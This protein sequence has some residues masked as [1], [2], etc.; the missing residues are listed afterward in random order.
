VS[1][2][3]ASNCCTSITARVTSRP[4]GDSCSVSWNSAA[5]IPKKYDG[6]N[7]KTGKKL[8]HTPLQD[9]SVS[10]ARRVPDADHRD[11]WAMR[12]LHRHRHRARPIV[13]TRVAA[14]LYSR[15]SN[16]QM[17]D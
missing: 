17:I 15:C 10:F 14:D 11:R 5:V 9:V 6:I 4:M 1:N 3:L 16:S 8:A 7:P 12:R 13:L 2:V